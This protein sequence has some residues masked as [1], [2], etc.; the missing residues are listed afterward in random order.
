MLRDVAC[1]VRV[2][3]RASFSGAAHDLRLSQPAVSQ[4]IGR[5]E[6]SFGTR[7]FERG[8]RSV[9]LTGPGRALLPYAEALLAAATALRDEAARQAVPTIRLAYPPLVGPLVARVARRLAARTPAVDVDL[10]PAGWS[11]ATAALGAGD[12]PAAILSYPFPSGRP[13]TARF[14]VPVAH[15]AV[16]AG[17]PLAAR[18]LLRPAD[19]GRH[20]MLLPATRPPGSTWARLAALVRQHRVVGPDLDD[21]AAPLDLVAAGA[22]VLATPRLVVETV[23]RPDVRFVPLDAGDLRITYGLVWAPEAA[24]PAV[25]ALVATVQ[26]A[27]RT[28]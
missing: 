6:R 12:V 2:A 13:T 10:R 23:R 11:A 20:R 18:T 7:L 4:A 27:L 28:R 19:L 15:L 22:G 16:P 3:E 24:S 21:F 9:R 5:L 14:Q 25:M 8:N 26:E 17:G 1:F